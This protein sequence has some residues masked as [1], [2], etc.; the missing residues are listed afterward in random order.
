MYFTVGGMV[1]NR[2]AIRNNGN[3][4]PLASSASLTSLVPRKGNQDDVAAEMCARRGIH[5]INSLRQRSYLKNKTTAL[6]WTVCNLLTKVSQVLEMGMN[7]S[8]ELQEKPRLGAG[9]H[10]RL[11]ALYWGEHALLNKL[12]LHPAE[13]ETSQQLTCVI[14]LFGSSRELC[15]DR[16][17]LCRELRVESLTQ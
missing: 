12:L 15:V 1:N 6:L 7:G 10:A 2:T 9:T 3:V 13:W 4:M 8:W 5:H 17:R 11:Q 16:D 14:F